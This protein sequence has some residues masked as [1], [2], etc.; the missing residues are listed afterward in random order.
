MSKFLKL[1]SKKHLLLSLLCLSFLQLAPNKGFAE[2]VCSTLFESVEK[3]RFE[4]AYQYY[5]K[6]RKK[7]DREDIPKVITINKKVYQVIDLLGSGVEG[8]VVRIQGEDG[9]RHI[10]KVFVYNR[11]SFL[12]QIWDYYQMNKGSKN[13]YTI[14]EIDFKNKIFKFDDMRAIPMNE[15]RH[16]LQEIKA[17]KEFNY[18]FSRVAME[19]LPG[20]HDQNIVFDIDRKI[21]VAI[22]PH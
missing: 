19:K 15:M 17:D 16:I 13:P 3:D 4:E 8:I 14:T 7:V 9:K 10:A 1:Y 18:I 5:L 2:K 22:D 11:R 12:R 21:F 6:S 20:Y